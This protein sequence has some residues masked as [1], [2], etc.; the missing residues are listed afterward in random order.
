MPGHRGDG[1]CPPVSS[2]HLYHCILLNPPPPALSTVLY[3]SILL[4]S[5]FFIIHFISSTST[6]YL[7]GQ[8]H[9]ITWS[10]LSPPFSPVQKVFVW[11]CPLHMHLNTHS[12]LHLHT[13][14]DTYGCL[15]TSTTTF[16]LQNGVL[17][18]KWRMK[19]QKKILLLTATVLSVLLCAICWFMVIGLLFPLCPEGKKES[20]KLSAWTRTKC[21]Q[22]T[23]TI[24]RSG[25]GTEHHSY[26]LG[27]S[28]IAPKEGCFL[29][30]NK[31]SPN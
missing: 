14:I 16:T 11:H 7:R 25:V 5:L 4:L 22:H 31:Y 10:P 29:C 15:T 8:I 3:T 13:L 27:G 23:L 12:L 20:N 24:Q 19:G 18:M 28:G 1:L 30:D 9:L 2:F 17:F 21:W 6:S 26:T